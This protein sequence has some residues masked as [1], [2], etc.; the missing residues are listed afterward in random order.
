MKLYELVL[1]ESLGRGGWLNGETGKYIDLEFD[2]RGQTHDEFTTENPDIFGDDPTK[3]FSRGWVRIVYPESTQRG[4]KTP[5][6]L[7]IE[8]APEFVKTEPV[9]RYVS[10]FIK[11][12]DV[13]KVDVQLINPTTS[14]TAGHGSFQMPHELRQLNV[15]LR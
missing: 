4:P 13:D 12:W 7:G 9:R 6:W 14:Y 11:D 15:F 1:T 5:P 2:T 10:R 3:V 8:G